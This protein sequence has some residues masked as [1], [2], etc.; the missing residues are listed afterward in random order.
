[1]Q[2][3]MCVS[4]PDRGRPPNPIAQLERPEMG[5]GQFGKEKPPW[6]CIPTDLRDFLNSLLET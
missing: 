6:G 2:Q 1:M 3:G 5:Q 4:A